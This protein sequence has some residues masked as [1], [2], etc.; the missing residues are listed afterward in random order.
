[1]R[2]SIV[3]ANIHNH[4][5][6]HFHGFTVHNPSTPSFVFIPKVFD[7]S[8]ILDSLYPRWKRWLADL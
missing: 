4:F 3:K 2:L 1:M 5:V 6:Q 8:P 7:A